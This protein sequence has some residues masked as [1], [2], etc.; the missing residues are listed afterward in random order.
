MSE[1]AERALRA[2]L[3]DP[4]QAERLAVH[5][6]TR[7]AV[8]AP[9]YERDGELYGVFT[10]RRAELRQHPGQISFP[11]GRTDPGDTSLVDTALREA[12]EEIGLAAS[13]VTIVGALTPT[14]TVVTDIAVYPFVGLIQ[15]PAAWTVAADEVAELLELALAPLAASYELRAMTRRG[16][17]FQT[18][19]F[20]AG[21][22]LIWGATGRMLADLFE[23]MHLLP[24]AGEP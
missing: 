22:N 24:A 11:G 6:S 4:A 8:L 5:G 13:A 9:L 18:D 10:K 1:A 19:T 16:V 21:T 7:A 20:T 12:H 14:P 2:V 15:R 23:R 17:R 3:L